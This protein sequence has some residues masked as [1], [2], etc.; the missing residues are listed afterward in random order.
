MAALYRKYRPKTFAEMVSQEP[1]IRAL[2]NQIKTG[3]VSHAYLFCGTRGTGK[4]STAKIFARAVNCLHPQDGNPCNVCD[5]CVS[6]LS[7][8]NIDVSEIDAASNNGVDNVRELRDEVKYPPTYGQYKVYIIDE[9]HMLS[10]AAFNALLKTLEE[11][12]E[13]LIFI[14][15]TTESHKIPATIL[16]RCQRY[17]FKRIAKD[18]MVAA[19]KKY[20]TAENIN[21]EDEALD[22]VAYHSDGA[23]RDALSILD[24]CIS[25]GDVLTL[26]VV[27]NVLGA[28]DRTMLADVLGA[29][30]SGDGAKLMQLIQLAMTDGRDVNQ[31]AADLIRYMRDVLVMKLTGEAEQ[32][33]EQMRIMVQKQSETVTAAQLMHYVCALS[34]LQNELRFVPHIRTAFEVCVLKLCYPDAAVQKAAP[35]PQSTEGFVAVPQSS[36]PAVSAAMPKQTPAPPQ[37]MPAPAQSTSTTPQ[38][39]ALH[40]KAS[41]TPDTL[42][43]IKQSWHSIAGSFTGM[44]KAMCARADIQVHQD[45]LQIMC[46]SDA[47]CNFLKNQQNLI[48]EKIAEK[49]N[50]DSPPTLAF[51]VGEIYNKKDVAV[52][53]QSQ[54]QAPHS[55]TTLF[56]ATNNKPSTDDWG[57]NFAQPVIGGDDDW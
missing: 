31:F 51:L 10:N 11:P 48:R 4:T 17:D 39:I 8:R 14:L 55:E 23:M 20:L 35:I 45:A 49:F 37:H 15:A 26:E 43:H 7:E 56:E 36:T 47:T 12:P 40:E 18:A 30:V 2:T 44:L 54:A 52:Q 6:I 41:I 33:S 32:A 16:S 3:S 22:Y 28:V 38:T 50:L 9:V 21:F 25:M 29:I 24:Q 42:V 13:H 53:A 57:A 46:D 1:I 5:V 34:E 19:L 27:H